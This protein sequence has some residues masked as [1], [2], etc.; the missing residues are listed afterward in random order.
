MMYGG[1]F[2]ELIST[3]S[4]LVDA[5]RGYIV[6]DAA[7]YI[8][9]GASPFSSLR[10]SV[11]IGDIITGTLDAD[12]IDQKISICRVNGTVAGGIDGMLR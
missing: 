6:T 5:E 11:K 9:I 8:L 7:D 10:G 12:T 3:E 2:E 4:L 1:Y